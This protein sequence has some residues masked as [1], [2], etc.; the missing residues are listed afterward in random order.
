VAATQDERGADL[1]LAVV[2]VFSMPS[3]G[4]RA[5]SSYSLGSTLRI[6]SVNTYSIIVRIRTR[7]GDRR[8]SLDNNI[9][10]S[11]VSNL[12]HKEWVSIGNAPALTLLYIIR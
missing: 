1:I 12:C 9:P 6:S 3:I 5:K 10:S 11:T 4:S 2:V 7:S 8:L